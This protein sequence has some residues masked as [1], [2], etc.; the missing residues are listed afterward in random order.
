ML[1]AWSSDLLIIYMWLL[2]HVWYET[3]SYVSLIKV[4]MEDIICVMY[5][6]KRLEHSIMLTYKKKKKRKKEK[7]SW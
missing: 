3:K 5:A 6:C 4:C 2:I 7:N 1:H